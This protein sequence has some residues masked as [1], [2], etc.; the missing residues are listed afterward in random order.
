M[1]GMVYLPAER[2]PRG[3]RI[4]LPLSDR[5]DFRTTGLIGMTKCEWL[6]FSGKTPEFDLEVRYI[7]LSEIL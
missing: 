5:G 1:T 3:E 2:V 7:P 4:L 6:P